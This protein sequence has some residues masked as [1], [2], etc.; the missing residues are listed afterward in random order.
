MTGISPVDPGI[1]R[2]P[3]KTCWIEQGRDGSLWEHENHINDL[4]RFA[5]PISRSGRM[6]EETRGVTP[7]RS[8]N[9]VTVTTQ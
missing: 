1:S 3:V 2:S 5:A 6:P 4:V 9:T 8:E 7:Y